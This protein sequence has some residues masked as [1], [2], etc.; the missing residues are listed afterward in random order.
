VD[1]LAWI[2]IALDILIVVG[3]FAGRNWLRER[4]VRGVQHKFDTRLEALRTELR[5]GEEELK[6]VLRARESDIAALREGVLSG[7]TQRQALL[8]KRRLEAVERVWSSVV[9]YGPYKVISATL[10][11]L[12]TE[13]VEREVVR[14]NSELRK[15]F[16]MLT[17]NVSVMKADSPE[18]L[19]NYERPFVSPLAWAYF[20]AYSTILA[21]AFARAKLLEIGVEQS[22]FLNV[23]NF[24][25]LLRTALPAYHSYIDTAGIEAFHHLVDLLEKELLS[26]L[27]RMLQGTE[28]DQ[29][30]VEQAA[31]IVSAVEKL[32]EEQAK[33]KATMAGVYTSL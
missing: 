3:V 5:K 13:A 19:A 23:N 16:G 26:E 25:D 4:I 6:S 7:R 1:W 18:N 21:S 15:F 32:A 24:R 33:Q 14:P 31:K 11:G 20:S 27:A 28:S 12:K 30:S 10:A 2:P 29:A 9:A 22:K 17:A 8:D